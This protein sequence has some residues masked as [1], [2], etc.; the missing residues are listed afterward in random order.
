MQMHMVLLCLGR[1]WIVHAG[2]LHTG[3]LPL[4]LLSAAA[5]SAFGAASLT[6]FPW[7]A[8]LLVFILFDFARFVKCFFHG[9]PKR[10]DF[11]R[12]SQN[13]NDAALY[14]ALQLGRQGRHPLI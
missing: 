11:F 5:L 6:G 7:S 4:L 9:S 10:G 14:F 2:N 13:R 1:Y 12:N 8:G 3:V